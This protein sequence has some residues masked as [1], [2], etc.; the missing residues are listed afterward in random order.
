[1]AKHGKKY[2]EAAKLID[3]AKLY[4][5]DEGI[6]IAKQ[7]HFAKFDETME[8]HL[9]TGLDTRHADQM[10]RGT[11]LLPH[12]L[13]KTVRVLVFA[14]GEAARAAEEAGAEIVGGDELIKRITDGFLDFDVALAER[15]MMGKVARLGRVLGPRGLMPNPRSGTVVDASDIA[16]GVN[17]ARQG[18]IE[19]RTDKTALMHVP[20]GKVS[21]EEQ[22]L[23]DNLSTVVDAIVKAKPTGAKGQYIRSA[24]LSSTMGPG[25]H[26]DLTPTLA[27][28][29][30]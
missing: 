13:G 25:V 2:Q 20:I 22:A 17:D 26:L 19:F 12:G 30:S 24:T 1:M 5:P 29:G 6:A 11:A 16:K 14:E 9:R 3:E 21:F 10:V 27:L 7:A 23:L 8:L 15:N 4:S 28:K 18:R